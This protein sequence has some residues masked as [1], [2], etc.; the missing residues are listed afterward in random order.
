MPSVGTDAEG[1]GLGRQQEG[2][3]QVLMAYLRATK[4]P[5]CLIVLKQ[6]C[7]VMEFL[8]KGRR[9]HESQTG[10]GFVQQRDDEGAY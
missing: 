5:A 8:L 3:L 4:L 7:N 6:G 10:G 2:R 1:V 9:G